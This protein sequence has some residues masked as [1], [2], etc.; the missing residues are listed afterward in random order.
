PRRSS[1]LLAVERVV[2][3]DV[4]DVLS[5]DPGALGEGLEGRARARVVVVVEVERPVRPAD[6]LLGV[7]HVGPRGDAGARRGPAARSA[8]AA[9]REEGAEACGPCR[10]RGHAAPR[11]GRGTRLLHELA[12][13]G[14]HGRLSASTCAHRAHRSRDRR[15]WLA[16]GWIDG[17]SVPRQTLGNPWSPSLIATNSCPV[18]NMPDSFRLAGALLADVAHDVLAA[19][20]VL[21]AVHR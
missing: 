16:A 18:G 10:T 3:L 19:R 20:V 2:V 13:Q 7:R 5:L 12:R 8:R 4:L 15:S 14:V 21:E 6:E 11:D 17:D 1:D 9:R